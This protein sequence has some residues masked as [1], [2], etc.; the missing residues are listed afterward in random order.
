MSNFAIVFTGVILF[1]I[2]NNGS[3]VDT[4]WKEGITYMYYSNEKVDKLTLEINSK[5]QEMFDSAKSYGMD[6][7]ETLK[8]SQE[9]DILINQ[10]ISIDN[11]F[12]IA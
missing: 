2:M 7:V 4:T 6:S 11:N 9:L 10:Y 8:V 12:N 5:R 1:V 3:A